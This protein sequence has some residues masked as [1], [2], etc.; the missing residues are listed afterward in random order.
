M[1]DMQAPAPAEQS[2][3]PEPQ[4]EPV[5][6]D[7][8]EAVKTPESGEE[9]P[10]RSQ[11]A[12]EA[13]EKAFSADLE[14]KPEA[15]ENTDG[16]ARGPDG[17]FVSKDAKPDEAK[18]KADADPKEDES[19]KADEKPDKAP[20]AEPPSRFSAD[21]KEAWNDAPK[22][23]QGEI[24]RAISEMEKGLQQ[25]DEQLAPLKPF[26]DMAEKSGTTVHDALN[27]YVRME[28]LLRQN[29][30][31]GLAAIAQNMGMTLNG[32]LSKVTGQQPEQQQEA[33]DQEILR[34]NQQIQQLQQ[35]VGGVQQTFQQQQQ[36]TVMSQVEKF[37]ADHPRF[38]ELSGEIARLLETGYASDLDD[39]YTKAERL[40]PLPQPEAPAPQP[41]AAAQPRSKS[42]KGA[43]SHGSNP[44]M[45]RTPSKNPR[46]ALERAFS[47]L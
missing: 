40:N 4:A 29:P 42:I 24:H 45:N 17:K 31:Q 1:D 13:L 10:Q 2:P 14:D 47:G 8:T 27:S 25:K 22:S 18:A 23:V 37:A 9:Q 26:M 20:I 30:Q 5:D 15:E 6:Q 35:Q 21:A 32:L 46:E 41:E 43:P 16:P 38:D 34:L 12:R 28:Q 44:A 3:I 19:A 33:K 7:T 39:A 11:S 36:Q